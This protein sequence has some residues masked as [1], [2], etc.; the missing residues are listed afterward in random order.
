MTKLKFDLKCA[1]YCEADG[2]HALRGTPKGVIPFY[3]TFAYIHHPKHGHILFDTGYTQRF[4][5]E[6]KRFPFSIYAAITKVYIRPD[7]YAS[8]QMNI[9]G[10][11]PEEVNY[12]IVSH[13]HADHIGGLKDFPNATFICAKSAYDDVRNRKGIS[14]LSKG[15][16]PNLMPSDF[17]SR[18]KFIDIQNASVE[19]ESLGKLYDLFDDES[20][21]LCALDGH[22][23]GQ[24]GALLETEK[25]KVFLVA[26]GAWLKQNYT[27]YHLPNPIVR[28]FFDSWKDFKSSLMRIHLYHKK[29]PETIIIPCHCRETFLEFTNQQK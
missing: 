5:E 22:A 2:S 9:Q 20:I 1:G 23:K 7:E 10:V 17:E 3:A 29:N 19:D 27:E 13:F 6:T 25:G 21:L 26:D 8:H 14:A 24:I 4:Y 18:A 15:F 12:I 16:V 28:L 11:S